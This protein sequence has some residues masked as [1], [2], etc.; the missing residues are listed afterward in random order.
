MQGRQ[1]KVLEIS[2]N[3]GREEI[4]KPNFKYV[5]NMHGD[6]VVGELTLFYSFYIFWSKIKPLLSNCPASDWPFSLKPV[7]IN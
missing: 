5:G 1:L 4:L 2:T 6:E 7:K 3:P